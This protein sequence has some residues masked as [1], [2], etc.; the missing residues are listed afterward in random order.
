MH[1]NYDKTLFGQ[2]LHNRRKE[3]KLTQ[4]ELADMVNISKNHLSSIENGKDGV[5][6]D[7]LC[8][9]CSALSASPDYFLM[10]AMHP[11]DRNLDFLDTLNL[12]SAE[13]QIILK[14]M[15]ELMAQRH[16]REFNKTHFE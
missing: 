16:S 5:S 15:A 12:C 9:F 3:Q 10:G 13:D 11:Y 7:L 8:D 1:L 6:V 4:E 14:Q 2:R